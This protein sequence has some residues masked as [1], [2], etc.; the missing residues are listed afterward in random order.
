MDISLGILTIILTANLYVCA[1]EAQDPIKLEESEE[2]ID[3]VLPNYL[4]TAWPIDAGLALILES[5]ERLEAENTQMKRTL[6]DVTQQLQE[7]RAAV[8]DLEQQVTPDRAAFCPRLCDDSI[9][10]SESRLRTQVNQLE[11]E[12]E[13]LRTQQTLLTHQAE[14]TLTVVDAVQEFQDEYI[15]ITDRLNL[16]EERQSDLLEAM[17]LA[18]LGQVIEPGDYTLI[19]SVVV[20]EDKK[21]VMADYV[22][23]EI[24]VVRTLVDRT[25]SSFLREPYFLTRRGDDVYVSDWGSHKVFRVEL[26]T[27]RVDSFFEGFNLFDL[28]LQ[29]PRTVAFDDNGN[30][31]VATE[32][33]YYCY[34]Y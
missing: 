18:G 21:L 7:T 29:Q 20:T 23:N 3:L 28:D 13:S 31:Y 17:V 19:T 16:V 9:K 1:A 22:Q 24:K 30:M 11:D 34:Y 14:I 4:T 5:L 12:V 15:N 33:I 8:E 2:G 32:F 25:G 27:G 6:S 26:E 10:A